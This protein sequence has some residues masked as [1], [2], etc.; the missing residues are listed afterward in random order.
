M[1]ST[2]RGARALCKHIEDLADA[3]ELDPLSGGR[4]P[5]VRHHGELVGGNSFSFDTAEELLGYQNRYDRRITKLFITL[6]I[7]LRDHG[8]SAIMSEDTW[9]HAFKGTASG[10]VQEALAIRQHL[11]DFAAAIQAPWWWMWW[12]TFNLLWGVGVFAFV[13]F[14][15]WLAFFLPDHA[16]IP[17]VTDAEAARSSGKV[18]L[19]LLGIFALMGILSLLR[20]RLFPKMLIAIGQGRARYEK[21]KRWHWIPITAGA[22]LLLKILWDGLRL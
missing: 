8:V 13:A 6:S 1:T 2:F 10:E 14:Y 20:K 15:L 11:E 7:G 22:G 4:K 3:A 18:G 12:N 21:L 19:S 5:K 16:V 9:S 17:K